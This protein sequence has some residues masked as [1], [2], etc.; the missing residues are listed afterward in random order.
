MSVCGQWYIATLDRLFTAACL[1]VHTIELCL[2]SCKCT[3]FYNHRFSI[4]LEFQTA[5][6]EAVLLYLQGSVY[7]DF[8]ALQLR[9][10]RLLFS[11]NLGSGRVNIQSENTYNDGVI[12]MVHMSYFSFHNVSVQRHVIQVELRRFE[13][14]GVMI[15]DNGVETRNGT[16]PGTFTALNINNGFLFL[17]G[18]PRFMNYVSLFPG[19]VEVRK[20]MQ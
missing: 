17:G 20:T 3:L 4:V 9:T 1:T 8:I 6:T 15:I 14:F 11:Y 16:S 18:I 19:G 13:Q 12:H 2:T 7:T 10:G 5:S